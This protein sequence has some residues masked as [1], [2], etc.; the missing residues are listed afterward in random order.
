MEEEGKT[1]DALIGINNRNKSFRCT[2]DSRHFGGLRGSGG[3]EKQK[4]N[5]TTKVD[6]ADL[7]R[8]IGA[9]AQ[10]SLLGARVY[11]MLCS[12]VV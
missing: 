12:N 11:I 4:A 7:E 9:E 1:E 10:K 2:A 6:L 3:A 8:D 5:V